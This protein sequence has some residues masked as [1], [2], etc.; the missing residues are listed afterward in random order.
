MCIFCKIIKNEV[1]SYK[2]YEDD[3]TLAIL[4]IT[5]VTDGHILVIPKKHYD[6]FHEADIDT[7]NNCMKTIK[8]LTKTIA[9]K[10]NIKGF[11]ILNNCNEAAGQTVMHLH[12]H[13]I[14]RYNNLDEINISFNRSTKFNIEEIYKKLID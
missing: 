5:Q 10:L 3:K 9:K 14:P 6:N 7:I 1:P 4:D 13:L 11:N 2:I 12:F 8:E